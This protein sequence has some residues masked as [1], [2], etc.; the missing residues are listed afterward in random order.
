MEYRIWRSSRSR[1]GAEQLP[2]G[3]HDETLTAIQA[4]TDEELQ[5]IAD[6]GF[7][8]VWVHGILH[9][10]VQVDPFPELGEGCGRHIEA[11]QTLIDRA[12]RYGIGVFLY[13][14]PPR[15]LSA[16]DPFWEKHPDI[17]GEEL[18]FPDI[19]LRCM[20]TSTAPVQR[21][22]VNAGEALLKSLPKLAGVILVTASEFAQHCFSH[23][24]HKPLTKPWHVEITCPRCRKRTR[25]EVI[26]E[27]IAKIHK[28]IRKSSAAAEVIAWNWSWERPEDESAIIRALPQDVILLADFERGGYKDLLRRKHFFMD[29]YSLGYAGPSEKF[30]QLFDETRRRPMR[31]MA[32]L[33]LGTT[34]ELATVVSLP[35]IG[36]LYK[37]AAFLRKNQLAGFMGCW[38]FGNA[39]PN[40]NVEAF[41]FFLSGECPDNEEEALRQ[42]ATKKFP[43]CRIDLIPAA[44][45]QFE[46]A[47][48]YY[49]FTILFL[50]FG[51]QNYTLAYDE[52][53]RPEPLT[54]KPVGGSW[55]MDERGDEL[56]EA[57]IHPEQP[58]LFDPDEIIERIGKV[59]VSW[60]AGAELFRKALGDTDDARLLDEL[61]NVMICQAVW[62][63]TENSCRVYKLRREWSDGKLAEFKRI[64]ED[65]LELLEAV[66]PWVERDERQGFHIE[67]G[68]VMFNGAMIR[69]KQ[70]V[71]RKLLAQK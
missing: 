45:K 48:Y 30:L 28:G 40:L 20:C 39:L 52:I 16:A 56:R 36:S 58:R 51:V 1:F 68:G 55:R 15:A 37:K 18:E 46:R 61:G 25:A 13:M 54:G 8:A 63:S 69:K 71:L 53:Y 67:P 44:W 42:F 2:T 34:H 35:I 65:E 27:V 4:Y 62:R 49:P 66:L 5:K 26:A 17:R 50:Y 23:R 9:H 47:M 6:A 19:T 60:E 43:G 59:A 29:E 32:K 57:W 14:Q 33:Q 12:E 24:C 38:N 41:N 21:Y 22:L 64:A 31:Q 7:N 11:M 70:C 10:L 3:E